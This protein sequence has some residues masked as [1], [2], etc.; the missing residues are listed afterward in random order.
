MVEESDHECGRVIVSATEVARF[1]VRSFI[2]SG[3]NQF[4]ISPG[5]RNAPLSLALVEAEERGLVELFVRI[6]E[7]SAAFFAL[8]LAKASNNYVGVICTSGTA[9]ANY[10]PAALEAYHAQNKVLF[11]SADRPAALRR[12]GANQTTLQAGLLHPLTSLDTDSAI[13]I[14]AHLGTGPLHLN[15][16]F[17]EPLV[18]TNAS[19]WLAGV[20]VGKRSLQPELRTELTISARTLVVV[21]HDRGGFTPQVLNEFLHRLG[22]PV[23]AEDPL[24][25]PGAIAHAS[26]F[27]SDERVREA[28]TPDMVIVI[29]R[30]T[31]SRSTNAL[32]ATAR[33]KIVIDPRITEIDT[34]RS[35]D[36]LLENLP[37]CTPTH[38]D[39]NWSKLWEITA[40]LSLNL[41]SWSEQVVA[42]T[43]AK[44]LPD[45]S[46]LFV[47]SSRPIR[48]IEAVARP[49]S[50]VTTYANRGLA[51]IDGNISTAFGIAEHHKKSYAILGDITFLHDIGALAAPSAAD[52]TLFV[53][54]NN[55]GG[56]FNTLEQ[57][58]VTGFEKVFGTPHN[59]DLQ[60][61]VTGF[62]I[63][64]ERVKSIADLERAVVHPHSGLKVF[65]VEVPDRQSNAA[66]LKATAQSLVS[67]LLTGANLA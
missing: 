24:G 7:R 60:A 43:I 59:V 41:G 2:E 27:L 19:D 42:A 40:E 46:A 38:Q 33:H 31:L 15:L 3:M 67:A 9:L 44:S 13:D 12:T 63:A 36:L 18:E 66:G 10:H 20:T 53:V 16:Q 28:F 55:G 29:G 54:D 34:A 6:D 26:L 25:V 14:T 23:I 64:C 56:I 62:G 51:G 17:T 30:T 22:V 47:A 48:D 50:G 49:R 57:A 58:G 4:V 5:S 1:M 32:I 11:I 39:E 8:G 52:L 61:I 35:A 65:V 21:G 45:E 37:T